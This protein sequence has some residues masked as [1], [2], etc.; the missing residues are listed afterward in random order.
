LDMARIGMQGTAALEE[1]EAEL[2]ERKQSR[3]A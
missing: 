1:K 2:F 3:K